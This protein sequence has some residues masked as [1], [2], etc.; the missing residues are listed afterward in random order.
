MYEKFTEYLEF[1][2]K[3]ADQ[4]GD[5][6]AKAAAFAADFSQSEFMNPNAMEIMGAKGWAT[7]SALLKDAPSMTAE[8]ACACISGFV[9]QESF[10]PGVLLD[11]IQQGILPRILER[12]K[13]L[14]G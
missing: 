12:L 10:I 5:L 9:M 4:Q 1:F 3:N 14:D 8:D 11:Q 6:S 2:G 13:E 7:R